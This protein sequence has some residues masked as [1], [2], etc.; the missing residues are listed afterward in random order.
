MVL[1]KW[2]AQVQLGKYAPPEDK[3]EEDVG[4]FLCL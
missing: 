3:V 2:L 4:I 1:I